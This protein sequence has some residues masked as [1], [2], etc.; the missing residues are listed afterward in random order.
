[1]SSESA[2][3]TDTIG[4]TTE[5]PL[6]RGLRRLLLSEY[7]VLILTIVY[8]LALLPFV[9]HLA[10][11]RNLGNIF[12]NMWPLLAV[13]IGQTFVLIVAGI[14][15]SQT[16]VMA[17]T[18]VVGTMLITSNLNPELFSKSP[19]W[20]VMLGPDGGPLGQGAFGVSAALAVMLVLGACIG[21]V[22]GVSV[23]IF[24]MPP[25]MVTFVGFMFFDKVALYLTKSENIMHLPA[26][27]IAVSK[28][29]FLGCPLSMF[30]TASAAILAYILLS[31]TVF[32]RWLYAT[33]INPKAA[34]VSGVPTTQVIIAAY[35][36]SGMCAG[37]GSIL[38]TGRLE[39]G[40]PTLGSNLL[41]DIV[42]ANIIGGISL[43]GGKGKISWT[44]FGVLFFVVLGNSLSMLN[45]D[46]FTIDIV[47]GM[48]ILLAALFDV[49]RNKFLAVKT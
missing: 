18:S 14:D 35:A 12:S 10:S 30:V 25:F 8:F 3:N 26:S 1:L 22:N 41:L 33:G 37:L 24:K 13:A 32:G 45:L 17:L 11:T 36:L 44:L 9:P 21:I 42:G 15:L 46:S 34:S 19:L 49:A 48:V 38:Y 23:A 16:S 20:G 40:R 31:K 2:T 28:G 5:L 4:R 29:V 6:A 43:F 27:F 39:C 7:F 47:K